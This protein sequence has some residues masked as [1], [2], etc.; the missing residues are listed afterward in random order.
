MKSLVGGFFYFSLQKT[1][2]KG[3]GRP[4]WQEKMREGIRNGN[5]KRESVNEN[6]G[7]DKEKK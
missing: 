2:N 3:E 5:R 6:L 4:R 1:E 7:G